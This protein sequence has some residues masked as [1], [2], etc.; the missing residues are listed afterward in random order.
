MENQEGLIPDDDEVIVTEPTDD[1]IEAAIV[2]KFG[3][4][5]SELIKK[6]DQIKV[7]TDEEKAEAE[8]S[9]RKEVVKFGLDSKIF[10]TQEYESFIADNQSDKISV[11]RKKYIEDHKDDKN[12]GATFDEIYRLDEEDE[13]E[14]G[15]ETK[16]N[17]KKLQAKALAEKLGT[18][19]IDTKYSKIKDASS[20]Y[21]S[22]LAEQSV[23]KANTEMVTKAIAEIP[24]KFEIE[25]EKGKYE[26]NFPEADFIE[27]ENMVKKDGLKNKDLKP[28]EVKANTL[29]FLQTKN[30]KSII[31]EVERVAIAKTVDEMER[32][33]SGI[34]VKRVQPPAG[35]ITAKEGFLK[36]HG[37][38]T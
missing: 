31:E 25:T 21:E 4:S 13:F 6:Q 37:I 12:A 28:E 34:D 7:L 17:N 19:L 15:E 35:V 11:L 2:K 3:V 22:H 9:K 30:L 23:I 36:K 10:T 1:Q 38:E 16:P 26:F 27:A 18:E 32:G 14:D 8:E 20:R 33:K 24:K 29:L 5:S